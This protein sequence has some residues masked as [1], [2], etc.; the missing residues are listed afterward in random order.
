L[1][2]WYPR[3]AGT[4]QVRIANLANLYLLGLFAWFMTWRLLTDAVWILF[5]VNALAAYLF[6]LVPFV[7]LVGLALRLPHLIAGAGLAAGLA[8]HLWGGLFT[9]G[10][11]TVSPDLPSLRV[12]TYNVLGWNEATDA[13]L[14]TIRASEAD[15][16]A[17][18]ELNPRVAA[19]IDRELASAYPYRVLAPREGVRGMGVISRLPLRPTSAAL[20][21]P[22][23]VSEPQ[24]LEFDV[25]GRTVL[26]VN[27]HAAAGI[28]FREGRNRQASLLAGFARDHDLPLLLLGDLNATSTNAAYDKLTSVLKDSWTEAGA[29]FGHT[30]PGAGPGVTPGSSRPTLLGISVP[31]WLVRIDYVFHSDHWLA[32]S[33]RLGLFDRHADHRPVIA[34]LA[35]V[36]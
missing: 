12:M 17:L 3:P 26:L 15:I 2:S 31:R 36:R 14:D 9:G 24:S 30:F 6:V 22:E 29:G 27:F 23:W 7:F 4:L 25:G 1:L 28:F 20:P 10:A 34:D 18:Q 21:D 5:A 16:V 13:V 8:L 32:T 33:A 11:P 35:L 19:V